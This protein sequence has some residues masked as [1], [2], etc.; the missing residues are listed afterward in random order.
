MEKKMARLVKV[1]EEIPDILEKYLVFSR[2]KL[3]FL[4][5]R[6]KTSTFAGPYNPIIM[7]YRILSEKSF[8]VQ[9]LKAIYARVL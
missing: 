6:Y 8:S 7:N 5:K 2:M 3:Y 1:S 9:L 4:S